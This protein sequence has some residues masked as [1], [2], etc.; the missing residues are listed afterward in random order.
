MASEEAYVLV[1][2]CLDLDSDIPLTKKQQVLVDR[3]NAAITAARAEQ[4]E[5]DAKIA[6]NQWALV[7]IGKVAIE[8][9]A[10]VER[11]AIAAAIRAGKVMPQLLSAPFVSPG[12]VELKI[13]CCR[14]LAVFSYKQKE[15]YDRV[16][17]NDHPVDWRIFI[18]CPNCKHRCVV[19]RYERNR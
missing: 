10:E 11:H 7:S 16:N 19:G 15:T 13:T 17:P 1:V 4:R 6:E 8:N 14:C 12:D 18:D 2:D 3:I 9:Q 5:V